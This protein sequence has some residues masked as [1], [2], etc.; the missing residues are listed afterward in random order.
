MMKPY[1]ESI[2][3]TP[4][5]H[6]LIG[7][8]P[9]CGSPRY[10]WIKSVGIWTCP[11]CRQTFSSEGKAEEDTVEA[12]T[13]DV[14]S[15]QMTPSEVLAELNTP[16]EI[17]TEDED[18]SSEEVEKELEDTEENTEELDEGYFDKRR[19]TSEKE[20]LEEAYAFVPG[21]NG[22]WGNIEEVPDTPTTAYEDL[23]AE[24][25]EDHV[26]RAR[27]IH[28]GVGET[29]EFK[30]SNSKAAMKTVAKWLFPDEV[31]DNGII[32]DSGA[33]EPFTSRNLGELF[34]MHLVSGNPEQAVWI[35]NNDTGEYVYD[36]QGRHFSQKQT[37]RRESTEADLGDVSA[38]P[39]PK[40]GAKDIIADVVRILEEGNDLDRIQDLYPGVE[41]A[42]F[43]WKDTAN[44]DGDEDGWPAGE[45]PEEQWLDEAAN[46][47]LVVF[48]N[49]LTEGSDTIGYIAIPEDL[50]D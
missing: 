18:E 20:E 12:A 34:V 36:Q 17:V 6:F 47:N 44:K 31:T 14:S 37:H 48:D 22:D 24:V 13:D 8:C 41:F 19:G 46:N 40:R 11:V 50:L 49:P 28:R 45:S 25:D 35:R 4:E 21:K 7:D 2:E 43:D 39:E 30:A 10:R 26:Y 23:P 1:K 3:L 33:V 42:N 16:I 5:A 29:R 32:R 15:D 38:F 9:E 27:V